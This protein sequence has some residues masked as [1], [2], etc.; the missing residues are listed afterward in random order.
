MLLLHLHK[1]QH[2]LLRCRSLLHFQVNHPQSL[3]HQCQLR[4][5]PSQFS[6]TPHPQAVWSNTFLNQLGQLVQLCYPVSWEILQ[7][8][9][10][11]MVHGDVYWALVDLFFVSHPELESATTWRQSSRKGPLLVTL[12]STM[13]SRWARCLTRIRRTQ[14]RC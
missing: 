9:P 2:T 14:D 11:T 3:L 4:Q 6:H 7:R 12:T 8:I 1:S 13:T 5:L 10:K